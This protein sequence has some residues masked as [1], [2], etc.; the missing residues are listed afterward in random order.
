[1]NNK[2]RIGV[3]RRDNDPEFNGWCPKCKI[4]YGHVRN[5]RCPSCRTRL[6]SPAQQKQILVDFLK[7]TDK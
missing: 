7:E 6:K 5:G 2:G 4:T 1:M 3:Y